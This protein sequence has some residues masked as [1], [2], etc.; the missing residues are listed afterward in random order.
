MAA[1]LA[2]PAVETAIA[3]LYGK[4]LLECGLLVG[5]LCA[6]RI[7]VVALVIPPLKL[8]AF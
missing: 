6:D 4:T 3:A 1:V 5:L 2:E 8:L 7:H